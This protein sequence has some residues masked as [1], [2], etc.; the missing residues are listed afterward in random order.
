MPSPTTAARQCQFVQ[1]LNWQNQIKIANKCNFK[2]S[3]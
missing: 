2:L 3:K 1:K